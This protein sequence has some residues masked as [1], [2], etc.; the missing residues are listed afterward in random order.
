M[1]HESTK[2]AHVAVAM[3]NRAD[4]SMDSPARQL[5]TTAANACRRT[6]DQHQRTLN[7]RTAPKKTDQVAIRRWIEGKAQVFINDGS[8]FLAG[9]MMFIHELIKKPMQMYAHEIKKNERQRLSAGARDQSAG[10]QIDRSACVYD[11]L[12]KDV[13]R[14]CAGF[15]VICRG[16]LS[17][18]GMEWQRT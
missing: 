17:K 16:P 15:C 7:M 6:H 10:L 14:A 2:D 12:F 13:F 5:I 1:T 3:V 4:D 11:E 9:K 8:A 18:V